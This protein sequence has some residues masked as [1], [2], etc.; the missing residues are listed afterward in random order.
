M[1]RDLL[2]PPWCASQRFTLSEAKICC[3]LTLIW[4]CRCD[5]GISWM[6][7][8]KCS[9]PWIVSVFK[10]IYV[11]VCLAGLKQRT[12]EWKF[13]EYV[14]NV[15]ADSAI[16]QGFLKRWVQKTSLSKSNGRMVPKTQSPNKDSLGTL[17]GHPWLDNTQ[18]MTKG[19]VP[20]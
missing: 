5:S 6:L 10:S 18:A 1:K 9:R 8:V 17:L 13:S 3:S 4:W 14:Y 11:V 19:Q 2:D 20:A 7:R 15:G 16:Y 12:Q